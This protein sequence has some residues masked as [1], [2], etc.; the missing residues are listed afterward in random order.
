MRSLGRDDGVPH[1]M[2]KPETHD[3][4]LRRVNRERGDLETQERRNMV[5]TEANASRLGV[6]SPGGEEPGT[7][8]VR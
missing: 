8:E 3:P 6:T 1:A 2:R 5:A 7:L 4:N